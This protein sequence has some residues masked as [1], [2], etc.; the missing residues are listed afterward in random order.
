MA[1]TLGLAHQGTVFIVK[2]SSPHVWNRHYQMVPIEKPDLL[3]ASFAEQ[4]CVELADMV[5]G[6]SAHLLSF[7]ERIGYNLPARVYVQ[8]NVMDFAEVRVADA[9][10]ARAHGDVVHTDEVTFF[11]RLEARK[12]LDLFC[13]ALD[14]LVARGHAPRRVNFLGKFGDAPTHRGAMS[15]RDFL[16]ERAARWPFTVKLHTTLD[17]PD[18][19]EFLCT[20]DMIVVMPSRI[21]NSSMAVSE[22]LENRLAFIATAVGGTPELVHADDHGEV[23]VPP[24]AQALAARMEAALQRGHPIARPAYDNAANL[25]TWYRFHGWLADA[26]A[27]RAP[28][29]L[30]L[31]GPGAGDP[32]DVGLIALV[33]DGDKVAPFVAAA[34]AANPAE[35]VLLVTD[36]ATRKTVERDVQTA[37]CRVVDAV[38]QTAG[39]ALNNALE[40]MTHTGVVLFDG[41]TVRPDAAFVTTLAQAIG[42]RPD[43]L[44]TTFFRDGPLIGM[45]LGGDVATQ[46]T[47]GLAYGPE[48]VAGSRE[49]LRTAGRIEP[50]DTRHGLLHALITHAVE[51]CAMPLLVVPEVLLEWPGAAGEARTRAANPNHRYLRAKPLLDRASLGLRRTLLATLSSNAGVAPKAF[52]ETA[53]PAGTPVW[54]VHADKD[55][56]DE[57]PLRNAKVII[58]LDEARSTLLLLADGPGPCALTVNGEPHPMVPVAIEAGEDTLNLFTFA[59]PAQWSDGSVH[60]VKLTLGEGAT[61]RTRFVRIVRLAHDVFSATS[62]SAILNA[63][64]IDRLVRWKIASR[65]AGDDASGG[66]L[67]EALADPG[68]LQDVFMSGPVEPQP[69]PGSAPL[70]AIDTLRARDWPVGDANG[71]VRGAVQRPREGPNGAAIVEGWAWN[72]TEPEQIV[73]VVALVDGSPTVVVR[74]DQFRHELSTPNAALN[75]H[76]F[77]LPLP[78]IDAAQRLELRLVET[79]APL[80]HGCFTRQGEVWTAAAPVAVRA[81]ARRRDWFSR[82][83]SRAPRHRTG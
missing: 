75:G 73:H 30:A 15:V 52:R 56:S 62:G 44:M 32:V 63:E 13:T 54:L 83:W 69:G 40:E 55:R 45:P 71:P 4:T 35:L 72:R 57:T 22:A 60:G 68:A 79:G 78:P 39:E 65:I 31:A 47:T 77:A 51:R 27:A 46:F 9:R 74:A 29:A 23:L 12:G 38:G 53:R 82:W 34:L 49:A 41:L 14:L 1:K 42:T 19:L 2:T 24:T 64:A 20:R 36:A 11:G 16:I 76:G 21:E 70:P 59:I 17:Q 7:M 48:V 25:A 8:P 81:L 5:V 6:G 26:R 10:P 37:P 67:A 28:E 33:R 61:A 50:Y 58:G 66:F 43:A 80:R 18:A 3:V